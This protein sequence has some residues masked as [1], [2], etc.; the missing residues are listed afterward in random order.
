MVGRIR[1]ETLL[2]QYVTVL[3]FAALFVLNCILQDNFLNI[4]TI[5]NLITQGTTAIIVAIG[6]TIVLYIDCIDISV[7]SMMALSA[8]IFCQILDA[9]SHPV[10]A[11]TVC[12]ACGVVCG[13]VCGCL[14]GV[15]KVQPMIASMAMMYILRGVARVLSRNKI[16]FLTGNGVAD[17]SYYR[18]GGIIPIQLF[19][20]LG[21]FFIM[22]ILMNRTRF[23]ICSA[24]CGD[25]LTAS[26]AAGIQT[27]H[28]IIVCFILSA[29]LASFAGIIECI[30]VASV[31]PST[32]GLNFEGTAIA[33][34]FMGGGVVRGRK[35]NLL[36]T[37]FGA[38]ILRLIILRFNMWNIPVAY[39]NV[40]QAVLIVMADYFQGMEFIKRKSKVSAVNVGE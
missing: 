39:S 32:L 13:T 24:A 1:K 2:K 12:L 5:W 8:V 31:N 38:L 20:L 15:F 7:G 29:V 27:S 33:A 34:T 16:L 3:V 28:V 17:L 10:L 14:V 37:I 30:M 19:I 6:M 40:V 21:V 11:L 35:C 26:R 22:Y 25:S 23:G 36:G 4:K 18:V 9:T